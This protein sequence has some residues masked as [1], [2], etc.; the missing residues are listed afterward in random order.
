M[1]EECEFIQIIGNTVKMRL[2]ERDGSFKNHYHRYKTR[3]KAERMYN[4]FSKSVEDN[5]GVSV[6]D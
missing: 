2:Q 5:G 4:I 1:I 3:E 6:S